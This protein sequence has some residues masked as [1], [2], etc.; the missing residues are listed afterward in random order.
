MWEG[1]LV[2]SVR[3]GVGLWVTH[4]PGDCPPSRG[5]FEDDPC[6]RDVADECADG[7]VCFEWTDLPYPCQGTCRPPGDECAVPADCPAD[8]TCYL[9]YCVWCCPE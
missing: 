2:D 4:R 1:Y 7:L 3:G 8:E 5:G 6:T 9:G